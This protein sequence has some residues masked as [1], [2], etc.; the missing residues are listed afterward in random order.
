[1][2]S[3][4]EEILFHLPLSTPEV[5]NVANLKTSSQQE[6]DISVNKHVSFL[7]FRGFRS[8]VE[9]QRYLTHKFRP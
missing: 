1:M 8:R 9:D 4:E 6:N 5:K 3:A 2:H 7:F